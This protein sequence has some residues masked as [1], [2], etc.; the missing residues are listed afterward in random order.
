MTVK[1]I[2]HYVD[3]QK[4]FTE[5][6]KYITAYRH[7]KEN[8]KPLPGPSNYIGEC[9]LKIAENLATDRRFVKYTFKE[10]MIGDAV[11]NCLRY[12]YNFDPDKGSNPFAY[13]TQI[14]YYAFLRRIEKEKKQMY[15]KYRTIQEAAALG[16][17]TSLAP[18]DRE[19]FQTVTKAMF[20]G[21]ADIAEKFETKQEERRAKARNA[22][23]QESTDDQQA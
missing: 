6:V 19:H 18:E 14:M 9:L 13:I 5:M 11:E 23:K 12:L 22:R 10:D 4:F 20:E 7:A 1:P 16:S 2:N 21:L 17:I 3:N 15:V 8:N